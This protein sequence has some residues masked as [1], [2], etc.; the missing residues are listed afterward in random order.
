MEYT[1]V[2]KAGEAYCDQ[3]ST[4][5][6]GRLIGFLL[7]VISFVTSY[8]SWLLSVLFWVL[9]QEFAVCSSS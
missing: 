2:L 5:T 3:A 7:V 1:V 9:I 6:Q 8:F 4:P